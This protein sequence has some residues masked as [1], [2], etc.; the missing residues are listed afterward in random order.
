MRN[1]EEKT[2]TGMISIVLN[3]T[4][5]PMRVNTREVDVKI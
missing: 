1:P 3:T 2:I 5:S 4:S